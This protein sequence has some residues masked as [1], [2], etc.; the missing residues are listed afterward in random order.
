MSHSKV[1]CVPIYAKVYCTMTCV[2]D[3]S[4]VLLNNI[5]EKYPIPILTPPAPV[6]CKSDPYNQD[7]FRFTKCSLLSARLPLRPPVKPLSLSTSTGTSYMAFIAPSLYMTS[8]PPI[9]CSVIWTPGF[10]AW[11]VVVVNLDFSL[12][13]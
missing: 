7:L 6:H 13:C 5:R 8:S 2:P 10:R 4:G 12:L 11:L 9:V 3:V 1:T